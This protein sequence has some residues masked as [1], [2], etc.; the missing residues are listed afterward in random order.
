MSFISLRG[1][2]VPFHQA[3]RCAGRLEYFDQGAFD[4]QLE[5]RGFSDRV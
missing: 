5:R 4:A 1:Y 3:E 2:A